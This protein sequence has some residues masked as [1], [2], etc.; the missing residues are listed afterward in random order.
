MEVGKNPQMAVIID[1]IIKSMGIEDYDPSVVQQLLEFVYRHVTGVIESGKVFARHAN[2]KFLDSSD[3]SFALKIKSEVC[4]VKVGPMMTSSL[5]ELARVHN[6][7]PLKFVKPKD[8]LRLP[9]DH[10]CSTAVNYK[11]KP[12]QPSQTVNRSGGESW[13]VS[14]KSG[15]GARPVQTVSAR[16]PTIQKN[17]S[18]MTF[19]PVIKF[20]SASSVNSEVKSVGVGAGDTQIEDGVIVKA[21]APSVDMEVERSAKRKR[22]IDDHDYDLGYLNPME[23]SQNS[24]T[25]HITCTSV[26]AITAHVWAYERSNDGIAEYRVLSLLNIGLSKEKGKT[27]INL[28]LTS[29]RGSFISRLFTIESESSLGS[30]CMTQQLHYHS[31]E[32][33]LDVPKSSNS[34]FLAFRDPENFQVNV[35]PLTFMFFSLFLMLHSHPAPATSSYFPYQSQPLTVFQ[36]VYVLLHLVNPLKPNETPFILLI[37]VFY[38]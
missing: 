9:A 12:G 3:I 7:V 24:M 8:G 17:P 26:I 36:A 20:S 38:A 15:V 23:F 31:L 16:R 19:K 27:G 21:K 10:Y 4:D 13:G 22:G 34:P 37:L 11:L 25:V 6:S 35:Y 18:L 32:L 33:H 1:S 30:I 5:K 14:G 28:N 2:K 29:S